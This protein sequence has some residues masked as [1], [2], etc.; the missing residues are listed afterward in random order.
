MWSI[1]KPQAKDYKK[2]GPVTEQKWLI[3]SEP[4]NYQSWTILVYML[5][6]SQNKGTEVTQDL[7]LEKRYSQISTKFRIWYSRKSQINT[8][9][10]QKWETNLTLLIYP[11]KSQKFLQ[12]L[13]RKRAWWRFMPKRL[14]P[15][16]LILLWRSIQKSHFI[17]RLEPLKK[18]ESNLLA[19]ALRILWKTPKQILGSKNRQKCQNH[20][21]QWGRRF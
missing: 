12:K 11:Q 20:S 5:Q 2:V 3:A 6:N 7:R 13:K 19:Q 16:L 10:S 9:F 17:S 15:R 8:D 18:S 21:L 14:M 4:Q 1:R